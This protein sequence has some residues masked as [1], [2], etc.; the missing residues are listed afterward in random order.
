MREVIDN[1]VSTIRRRKG[2]LFI[3]SGNI[4]DSLKYGS[5][6][7][8]VFTDFLVTLTEKKLTQCLY[9]DL[10]SGIK[11]VR[12]NEERIK[13]VGL[14]TGEDKNKK[15]PNAALIMALKQARNSVSASK[16]PVSPPEVFSFFDRILEKT[17][18][19]TLI[20]VDYADSIIPAGLQNLNQ[21]TDKVLSIALI[22]WSKNRI[23]REK[24]HLIFLI[25]RRAG[26]LDELI[27]DRSFEAVQFRIPKPDEELRKSFF[28][29]KR[30]ET[31]EALILSRA[32]S[33]L[34]LR[35][36]EA[37]VDKDFRSIN[38]N[39]RLDHVFSLKQKVL[40]DEYSDIL[41]MIT[42]RN[43]FEAIGGLE[44]A[45][46]KLKRIASYMR[47][48]RTSL[49][50][51]G[52][53]FMG[54]PGTGKTVL[55]E[56]LA[57]EA[58]LNFVKPL[59]IKMMWVGE[60]ERRMTRFLD[61]IKD[62]APVVVFIDEF[63]QNQSQRGGF[64]GDSGVSRSLFKKMLEIMSD[65]SLRGRVLWILATNRPDLIDA[66]IKRPGRC[67]LRIPFLPPDQEQLALICEAA[68]YQY[69]DIKTE[70][71]N[72]KP[73]IKCCN[74]YNGADM[75]EV[76]RR[77]WER[78]AENSRKAFTNQDMSWALKDYRPQ[79]LDRTQIS[80]MTTLALI[81]CS[82]RSL[83]PDNWQEVL[84]QIMPPKAAKAVISYIK[85]RS[86]SKKP[87]QIQ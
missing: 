55:A 15:D 12:G 20:I 67:D 7:F 27:L 52:I 25:T 45:I 40:K 59:D 56:A 83:I 76:I 57:K 17:K 35:E 72:W 85:S 31:K 70:V 22:K 87:I 30:F 44:K 46:A 60:S 77:A 51:Q 54:P 69:P 66:A 64:E 62:L 39:D 42:P 28:I 21:L 8:P 47:E 11:I 78:A 9:Y 10:F 26:D 29:E 14:A 63:D 4:Y 48:G 84:R 3:V 73:H 53:L 1:L 5:Q 68:F 32:S 36:L 37:L 33:G 49:V 19:P 43:G 79:S 71:K 38:L 13:Q 58:G 34:S 24:G 80:R 81:E 50:S 18:N 41:D 16:L 6:K 86:K 2:H 75:I 23:I 74:G 65:T 82:S 61:A